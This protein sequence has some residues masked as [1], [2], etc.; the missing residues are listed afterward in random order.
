MVVVYVVLSQIIYRERN[1]EQQY[2]RDMFTNLQYS[3][4]FG[5]AMETGSHDRE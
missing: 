3:Y 1:Y 2:A 5:L 4:I